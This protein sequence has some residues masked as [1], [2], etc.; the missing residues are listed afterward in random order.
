MGYGLYF[1]G[2]AIMKESALQKLIIQ[3]CRSHIKEDVLYWATSNERKAKPQ[4][5]AALKAMGM[6]PGVS[7][8]IFL[9]CDDIGLEAIFIELKRPASY[10]MGRRGKQIIN[11][12]GGIQSDRQKDFQKRLENIGGTYVLID[13]LKH[14]ICLIRNY[15]LEK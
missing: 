1:S 8:L 2:D 3:W 15:G 10:K 9:F 7:D 6:L 4:H 11:I 14:F 12:P 5:M 13:N